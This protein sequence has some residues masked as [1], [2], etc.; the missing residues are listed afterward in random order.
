MS[1][2]ES[3][4]SKQKHKSIE[5]HETQEKSIVPLDN[6]C[7]NCVTLSQVE[8]IYIKVNEL[9]YPR[10][11]YKTQKLQVDRIIHGTF[12]YAFFLWTLKNT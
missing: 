12:C 3:N 1:I 6:Y 9:K 11:N 5:L 4:S 10:R 8:K 2:K 7:I